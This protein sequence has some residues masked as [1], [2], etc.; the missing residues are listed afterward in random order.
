MTFNGAVPTIG[1]AGVQ[2]EALFME[3]MALTDSAWQPIKL[4]S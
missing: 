3:A 2:A 4:A 1:P